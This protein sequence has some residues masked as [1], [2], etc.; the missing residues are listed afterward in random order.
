MQTLGWRWYSYGLFSD[1]ATWDAWKQAVLAP[2]SGASDAQI[3][4]TG[5]FSDY[6]MK[7]EC[8]T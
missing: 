8:A 5:N 2:G 6:V 1:T 4:A 3:E 7:V